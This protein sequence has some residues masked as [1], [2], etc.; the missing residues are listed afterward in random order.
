MFL[1]LLS[2]SIHYFFIHYVHLCWRPFCGYF[3]AYFFMWFLY[4]LGI[5][6]YFIMNMCTNVLG[7]TQMVPSPKISLVILCWGV[8]LG[9]FGGH[10]NI[11]MFLYFLKTIQYFLMKF[12]RYYSDDHY[13]N[14]KYKKNSDMFFYIAR[15]FWVIFG[16]ILVY[17]PL[18]LENYSIFSHE[19]EYRCS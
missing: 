4:F 12:C 9:C 13:T 17:V 14:K 5:V 18:F 2:W 6:Q 7:S 1:V 3:W 10:F 15:P 16:S 8:I 19:N 11:H